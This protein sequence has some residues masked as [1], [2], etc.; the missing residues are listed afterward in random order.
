MAEKSTFV[1]I[2]RNMVSWRWFQTPATAHLWLY[3][4]I[5]ANI[6]PAAFRTI[7]VQR[8]QL[9]TSLQHLANDTGLTIQQVRTALKHLISTGEITD[10]ASHGYRLITLLNYDKYQTVQQAN[11]QVINRKSTD[12]PTADQHQSKN[13]RRERIKEDIYIPPAAEEVEAYAQAE[14]LQLDAQAFLDYNAS[15]GWKG[16]TD[17]RPLVRRWAQRTAQA[18]TQETDSFGRPIRKE[19]EDA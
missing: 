14:G 10:R 7:T 1:K 5:R 4:V 8:G 16:I 2:D 19:F 11:Q 13:T 12:N 9:V 15:R 17:W 3:L 18:D 6:K